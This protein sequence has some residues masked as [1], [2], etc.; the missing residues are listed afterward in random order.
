M[1]NFS[2]WALCVSKGACRKLCNTLVGILGVRMVANEKYLEN[3]LTINRWKSTSFE[4]LLNK[5][6]SKINAWKAP[7]LSQ[8]SRNAFIKSAVSTIPIYIMSMLQLPKDASDWI[9]KYVRKFLW[10]DQNNK[11]IIKLDGVKFASLLRKVAWGDQ[12]N[13]IKL[14]KIR[15]SE[16]RKPIAEGG[17]GVR[18]T[19]CNNIAL[20]AKTYWR[21]ENNDLLCAK[22]LKT[23]YYVRKSFWNA[24]WKIGN[25]WFLKGFIEA[26]KIVKSTIS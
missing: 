7:L 23:W 18:D 21:F 24:L 25:S 22:I 26:L 8:A 9:D 20:L 3:P 15:W 19:L 11:R 1:V 12:D 5:I 14:H 6:K 16:I 2:K 4:S 10:G 13:K 17:L